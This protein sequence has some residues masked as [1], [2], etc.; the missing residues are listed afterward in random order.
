VLCRLLRLSLPIIAQNVCGFGIQTISIF[1]LARISVEALSAAALA[2]SIYNVTG[3]N[4]NL[5]ASLA[6][7]HVPSAT[8]SFLAI[9]FFFFLR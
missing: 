2:Q 8:G 4:P 6:Q 9:R 7:Y 1:F 5:I 3:A